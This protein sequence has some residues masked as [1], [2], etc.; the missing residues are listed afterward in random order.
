MYIS[1]IEIKRFLIDNKWL[2]IIG[3]VIVSLLLSLALILIDFNDNS[4]PD[5]VDTGQD[6][7]NVQLDTDPVYFQ[8]YAELENGEKFANVSL[9]REF[10][11]LNSVKNE[12]LLETGININAVEEQIRE[13][14]QIEE[15]SFAIQQ[16]DRESPS[17]VYTV[18]V[19]TGDREDNNTLA[20]YYYQE[21]VNKELV[22]L[23]DKNIYVLQEPTELI[24][25]ELEGSEEVFEV[26][27]SE[28]QGLI[29][30]VRSNIVNI[31]IGTVIIFFGM[32]GLALLKA[33]FGKY[34]NYSFAY[35]VNEKDKFLLYDSALNNA[36]LIPSFIE[37][38][39]GNQKVI[40]SEESLDNISNKSLYNKI[41]LDSD[42]S[43]NNKTIVELKSL[44]GLNSSDYSEIIIVV[45]PYLTTRKWYKTQREILELLDHPVKIIQLNS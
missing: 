39:Y 40:V 17:N 31:V 24:S 42:N 26:S 27:D 22:F 32:V 34:L 12:V 11:E 14:Y 38:P 9:L 16:F 18:K 21:I 7:E 5:D 20:D 29:Q 30:V 43:T 44:T 23:E 6:I 8:F 1:W 4:T 19:N 25:E 2:I 41:I 36:D 10:Y 28:S 15:E 33:L 13:E 3:T 37:L 35:E 45:K